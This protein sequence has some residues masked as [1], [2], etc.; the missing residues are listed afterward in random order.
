MG[1]LGN[2][3]GYYLQLLGLGSSRNTSPDPN[4]PTSTFGISPIIFKALGWIMRTIIIV[5]L[6]S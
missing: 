2:M 3:G 4:D 6:S 5:V 1:M